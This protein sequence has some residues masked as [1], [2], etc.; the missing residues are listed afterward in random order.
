MYAFFFLTRNV[1]YTK[2]TGQCIG[3][4]TVFVPQ[5]ISTVPML[6]FQG[7][8]GNPGPV[9]PPGMKGDGVPGP[10]VRGNRV[11]LNYPSLQC[12]RITNDKNLVCDQQGLPGL[13]GVQGETGAEGKGLPGPKV[14]Q[15]CQVINSVGKPPRSKRHIC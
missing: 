15:K 6:P 7:N 12:I 13:P 14:R 4:L 11:Q 1:Q 10:Q 5:I 9:G 8:K 3:F 2:P